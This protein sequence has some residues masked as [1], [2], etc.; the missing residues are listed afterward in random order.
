MLDNVVGFEGGDD[1]FTFPSS[2][3]SC[4]IDSGVHNFAVCEPR[5]IRAKYAA[6]PRAFCLTG[7]PPQTVA[8]K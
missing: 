8:R 4:L 6:A 5:V 3:M 2:G 1:K 7:G